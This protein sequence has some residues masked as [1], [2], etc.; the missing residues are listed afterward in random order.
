MSYQFG[1]VCI[2]SR[3]NSCAC[4]RCFRIVHVLGMWCKASDITRN[5]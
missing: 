1:K 4:I 2:W 3:T 5:V